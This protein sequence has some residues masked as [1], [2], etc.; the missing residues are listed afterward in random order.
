MGIYRGGTGSVDLSSLYPSVMR[1]CNISPETKFGK[2]TVLDDDQ[3]FIIRRP[4]SPPKQLKGSVDQLK[5]K[6]C[7]SSNKIL[8]LHPDKQ[9]GIIPLFLDRLYDLRQKTRKKGRKLDKEIDPLKE[10]LK[11]LSG[12]EAEEL[13]KKISEM[14]NLVQLY[15]NTQH[16]YKIFL[17]S[18]Y[19]Q[20]G[21]SYFPLFD[22]DNA[23]AVTI[24]GQMI[25]KGSAQFVRD[26][27]KEKYGYEDDPTLA[28]DTDS[29]M[30]NCEPL[31]KHVLGKV[32]IE[33]TREQIDKVCKRLDR[34]L[35]KDLNDYCTKLAEDIVM[36]SVKT[37]EFKRETFCTESMFLAKKRY[38][39]RVRDDEGKPV[40]KWKCTGVDI[41][42]NELPDK[43]KDSLKHIIF[44]SLTERWD[45]TRYMNELEAIWE[46]FKKL[47]PDEVAYIKGY[48]TEKE[49]VG[50]LKAEKGALASAKAALF[51][52][53]LIEEL[54]LTNKYDPIMPGNVLRFSYVKKGNPYGINVIGWGD[55]WPAEFDD[56]FQIDY[57]KMF[58]KALM[59]PL[60]RIIDINAWPKNHP[61]N[62]VV[63]NVM[64]L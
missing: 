9:R 42:K 33:W 19:G 11:T 44:N 26:H 25:I 13:A 64:D 50:F 12:R 31:T 32:P 53:Q 36:S 60:K 55:D 48:N 62:Q 10:K 3:G 61:C 30:F 56:L 58:M 43:I 7:I 40:D 23:E 20:M 14:E 21:N 39:M 54:G 28:G 51:H 47:T 18:I 4:G 5:G 16:A 34:T 6:L 57:S 59:G 29:L 17:N 63:T 24:T 2:L 49:T 35:V 8:Y 1:M 52:N 46:K 37:I 27:F 38:V 22:L 45:G 15:D 41:K